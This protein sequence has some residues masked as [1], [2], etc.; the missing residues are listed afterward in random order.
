[1]RE[2]R[3]DITKSMLAGNYTCGENSSCALRPSPFAFRPPLSSLLSLLFSLLLLSGCGSPYDATVSGNVTL[4]GQP[5]TKGSVSFHPVA[6]GPV[7]NGTIAGDGSYTVTT[8]TDTGLPPGDYKVTVVATDPPPPGDEETP[9]ILLTP[10]KYNR[11]DTT[12]LQFTI[13]A[14]GNEINLP[15]VSTP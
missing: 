11:V 5:L 3:F 13:N 15:I 2:E 14:G 8:G 4:D 10:E 6:D 9:G 1:M 7:A 12:P